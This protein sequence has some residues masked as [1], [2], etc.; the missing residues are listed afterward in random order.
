MFQK[1]FKVFQSCLFALKSSQLPEDKEGLFNHISAIFYL[2]C[3]Q[4]FLS[5]V[6]GSFLPGS[7][8]PHQ[9]IYQT[10]DGSTYLENLLVSQ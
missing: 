10:L 8:S 1:C 7:D 6:S 4:I 2:T 9:M 5:S 3:Q